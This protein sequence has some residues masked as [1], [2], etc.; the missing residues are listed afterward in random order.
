MN[1]RILLTALTAV[2]LI[3]AGLSLPDPLEEGFRNPPASARP[4]VYY[5]WL[6]GYANRSHMETEIAQLKEMGIGGLCLFDMGARGPK[7]TLP[8]A[9]P[10]F[11]SDDSLKIIGQAIRTA[12]GLGMETN[13]SASSSWDLGGSWVEPKDASMGLFHAQIQLKGPQKYSGELPFP[14]LSPSV[15][16]G[17]NGLPAFHR[18]I[19]VLASRAD[20]RL[21]GHEFIYRLEA[22]SMVQRLA[23]YNTT[24]DNPAKE[25]SV[26]ASSTVP[27]NAAFREIWQGSLQAGSGSQKFATA[28]TE[29]RYLRL[30]V[31]S[32]RNPGVER[33]QLAEFEA[34]GPGNVNL[35]AAHEADRTRDGAELLRCS[36]ALGYD[37]EWT[38]D[39][40]NDG[41]KSG[42]AGTWSSEGP[43]ALVIQDSKSMVDL[44]KNLG[45]DGR[46]TW[47]MPPGEWVVWRFVCANT[48]ERLKLPS[49]NSDGWATDHLSATATRRTI[50]HVID[51]LRSELGDFH[52]TTFSGLYLASYE[53]R[54]PIW[55]P[56]FLAQFQRYRGYDMARFL[57]ALAGN[58]VDNEEIT[59]RFLYDY[60]KTLGDLLVDA[61]YRT[62][63]AAAHQAGL[64]VE[65]EAGG[66]GPPIHQVPVDAL[67]ALGSID[68]VRGEFWPRR[69]QA[70][71]MWVVKE[72]ACSAHIY[73]KPRVR[74]E[75]FTSTDHLR[76]GPQDLKGATDRVFCEGANQM[77]WHTLSHQPP[78]AGKPGWVYG[79]GSHLNRNVT[80]W[81]KSKPFLD[82]LARCSYLLQQGLFVADVLYYYGDQGFNFVPPKHVDP[83]LGYGYDYDVA[84]AEVVVN[85]L[86]VHD[87]R[88]VLPDGMSYE[89]LVLPERDDIDLAVLKKL[90]ELVEAGATIVGR[91]PLR[92]NGLTD[93]PQ[94]DQ[95]VSAVANKLWGSCDG[96]SVHEHHYGR[97]L[98]VCERNLR[99]LLERKGIRPDFS[100][101]S[102]LADS[103]L[104]FIHRRT[105]EAD[106]YFIRNKRTRREQGDAVFRVSGKAPEIWQPDNGMIRR[107]HVWKT[108]P[109]GVKVPLVFDPEGSLFI[110]F[111]QPNTVPHL[112][113]AALEILEFDGHQAEALAYG[114]SSYPV[115][116]ADGSATTFT[117]N[118][119]EPREIPGPWR[120]DFAPR[121][122]APAFAIFE[123]LRSWTSRTEEGIR[124]FSGTATYKRQ[125]EIP[126]DWLAPGRKVFV[127]LGRLWAIGAVYVNDKSIGVVWKQPFRVDITPCARAGANQLAVEVVNTWHNRL[128]GDARSSA[129]QRHTRT[130]ITDTSG[131]PWGKVELLDSGL[132]GPVR[133]IPGLVIKASF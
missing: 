7:D 75:A 119:P 44:T 2:P 47:D 124:Y 81:S 46:L 100:F 97:G 16:R 58:I 39:N 6:N 70:A 37:R 123:E 131:V 36:S 10:A 11:L 111:R 78:E 106:I 38:A 65:S 120:V 56:D 109:G 3:S 84:N 89:L 101:S 126:P 76:E 90:Q 91:K 68:V 121:W 133:L 25:V 66:P 33:V 43:P 113:D 85:R 15:P 51:R 34:Y 77:V 4:A 107:Q 71:Q 45:S 54:G 132:F 23:F 112:V 53:V 19:A 99:E 61:Y 64:N 105:P 118:L 110:V 128:A 74:M 95:E 41:A 96:L 24:G 9:G 26:A 92:A 30:R 32:G 93:Y 31:L 69:P 125:F 42:P 50:Q 5:I 87:G 21:P 40:L 88:L 79:A 67:K 103:D 116:S 98:V 60:R 114:S 48:G 94:R 104:D 80:W 63:T 115:R 57:P 20:R 117:V 108:V 17:P 22:P 13:L 62:A 102:S 52:G 55:T 28:P 122:G 129:S 18:D 127:D 29:A 1:S 73:G 27:R 12:T 83:S 49:P 59:E 130:N 35:I 14:A 72:T 82:Y 8:P 86:S